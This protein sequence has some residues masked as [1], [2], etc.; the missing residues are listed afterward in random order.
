M[1]RLI[2][3]ER[4][5]ILGPPGAGKTRLARELSREKGIPHIE[6]D[7]IFWRGDRALSKEE[8]REQLKIHLRAPSWIF[9]GHFGKAADLVI[10]NTVFVLS[11]SRRTRLWR[12][13][14][15]D[16]SRVISSPLARGRWQ[17]LIH[18]LIHFRSDEVQAERFAQQ[19]KNQNYKLVQ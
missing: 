11:P 1:P 2:S 7:K 8:F 5:L 12:L 10:P 6:A 19:C 4:I 3:E 14:R 17:K 13:L 15:R 9:E 18:N 16:I